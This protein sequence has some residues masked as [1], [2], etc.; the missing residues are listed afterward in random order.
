MNE[1]LGLVYCYWLWGVTDG[2]VRMLR[3]W[4]NQMLTYVN[5]AG[6]DHEYLVLDTETMKAEA[7]TMLQRAL[8]KPALS[9]LSDHS[10]KRPKVLFKSKSWNDSSTQLTHI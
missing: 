6:R 10:L 5:K 4:I 2:K 8:F 3:L 9:R 7:F 1:K